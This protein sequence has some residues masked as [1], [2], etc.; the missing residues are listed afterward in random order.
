M[1]F[2]LKLLLKTITGFEH[3]AQL[4]CW[5]HLLHEFLEEHGFSRI[6]GMISPLLATPVWN[7]TNTKHSRTVNKNILFMIANILDIIHV[8][9]RFEKEAVEFISMIH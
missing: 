1:A 2:H 7:N 6:R 8:S 4:G 3:Q 9:N 5:I